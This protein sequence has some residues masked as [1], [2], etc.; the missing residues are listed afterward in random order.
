MTLKKIIPILLLLAVLF[1]GCIEDVYPDY[2]KLELK[3]LKFFTN[4][5]KAYDVSNKT[6][7]PLFVYF[8]SETCGWC[9]KFEEESFT[10]SSIV[11]ILS[12]NF[13]IVSID[14]YK[15][16]NITRLYGVRG[17]PHELFLYANG[18]E[19][20]RLPGYVD[21]QTFLNT[22]NE[23]AFHNTINETADLTRGL[24]NET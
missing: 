23:I 15:Q 18:S 19:I 6:G 7:E 21:N 20:K 10:N 5:T 16:K 22:I 24:E 12:N 3:D 13:T 11:E 4:L 1:S 2:G 17:T 9:K 8:R 14:V